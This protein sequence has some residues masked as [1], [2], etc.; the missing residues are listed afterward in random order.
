MTDR[1]PIWIMIAQGARYVAEAAEVSVAY[2][3][4]GVRF[5]ETL[6]A[7]IESFNTMGKED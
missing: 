3:E 6:F 5:R 1:R 2:I 7:V 4:G